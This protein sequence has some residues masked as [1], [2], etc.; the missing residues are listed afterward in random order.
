M[1]LSPPADE[2][3]ASVGTAEEQNGC[4]VVCARC[5]VWEQLEL[6]GR[7]SKI[8]LFVSYLTVPFCSPL[9]AS[10]TMR[11]VTERIQRR[12]FVR[13]GELSFLTHR[14]WQPTHEL[15]ETAV[16]YRGRSPVF[17]HSHKIN[18]IVREGLLTRVRL[19]KILEYGSLSVAGLFSCTVL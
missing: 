17:G 15:V 1:A 18:P 5:C 8:Y 3:H 19:W 7:G 10:I 9:C 11:D 13:S 6:A 4:T 16:S 12:S 14:E 2:V